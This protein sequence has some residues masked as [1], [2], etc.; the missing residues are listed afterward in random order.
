M[1]AGARL[2]R[3]T[4]AQHIAQDVF[5]LDYPLCTLGQWLLDQ[6]DKYLREGRPAV[7]SLGRNSL[8]I[9]LN[10]ADVTL[11]R[12]G[13]YTITGG[14]NRPD[15]KITLA[16]DRVIV[17]SLRGATAQRLTLQ[18]NVNL[19]LDT[20]DLVKLETLEMRQGSKLTLNAGGAMAVAEVIRPAD[21]GTAE[22]TKVYI[23]GGSLDANL[24]ENKGRTLYRFNG[25]GATSVTVSGHAYPADTPQE[26]GAIACGCP[27]P[28][29]ACAGLL[30][31]G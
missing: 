29:R 16:K 22:D 31:G 7:Y 18:S 26:D 8:T 28:P 14:E 20:R 13:T 4:D 2:P 24:T 27:H 11:W 5:G 9:N 3:W 21:T 12:S 23:T 6:Q 10:L 17:L 1:R 25:Q 19:T 30:P 15:A